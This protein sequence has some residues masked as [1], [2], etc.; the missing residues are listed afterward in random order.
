[1]KVASCLKLHLCWLALSL[2]LF[3]LVIFSL[4]FYQIFFNIVLTEI[5]RCSHD[6]NKALNVLFIG[7]LTW[8]A[9]ET[10]FLNPIDFLGIYISGGWYHFRRFIN[11]G[12]RLFILLFKALLNRCDYLWL[13]L[14]DFLLDILIVSWWYFFF[15]KRHYHICKSV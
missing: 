15:L 1:M 11:Y 6:F 4:N 10:E 12:N 8:A 5:F 13:G 14:L 7:T 9:L 2:G 3:S